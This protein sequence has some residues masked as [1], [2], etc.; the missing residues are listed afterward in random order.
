[1]W[2][3]FLRSSRLSCRSFSTSG[4]LSTGYGT[5]PRSLFSGY[6]CGAF[7]VHGIRLHGNINTMMDKECTCCG[8]IQPI[9]AFSFKRKSLGL[10]R[11]WC[12]ACVKIYSARR[13]KENSEK[14]STRH[15]LRSLKAYGLSKEDFQAMGGT[16]WICGTDEPGGGGNGGNL[17]VDH[18]HRCCPSERKSC[19]K[20]VRGLLCRKC[21]TGL[22]MFK[23]NPELLR[24]AADYI[25]KFLG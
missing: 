23:D 11:S 12:R 2:S 21:N 16:C 5:G 25:E 17:H 3:S 10:R 6:Y 8:V 18:D 15:R 19:G 7:L 9:N 4:P 20:C 13:Y 24:G 22:G 1:M 14:I